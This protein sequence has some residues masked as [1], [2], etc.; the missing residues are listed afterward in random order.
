MN[1]ILDGISVVDLSWGTAG[2]IATMLLADSGAQVT[3]VRPPAGD[4]FVTP[5][6]LVWDRQKRHV[7]FDLTSSDG[8]AQLDGLL[9]GADVLIDS[10]PPGT[11]DR[12]GLDTQVLATHPRLVHCSIT[13]YGSTGSWRDRPG[14]DALVQARTG[15]MFEQPGHREAPIFHWVP[16]PSYGAGILA[17]IGILAALRERELSGLGQRVETS[18]LQGVLAWTTM[19]WTRVE[20]PTPGYYASYACKDVGQT[21]CYEAGDGRWI[22][23]MP[24]V[25]PV[26]LEVLGL[27]PDALVGSPS[28]PTCD[29]RKAFQASMQSLLLRRT[30]TEWLEIFRQ[31]DLRCQPVQSI[32]EAY[33]HPQLAATGAVQTIDV[34]GVGPVRQFGSPF[35]ITT[36][37][38]HP[39][40]APQPRR[41]LSSPLE[42][43]TVLDFGLAVAGPYGPM[44]LSDLGADVIRID[45]VNAPRA[46]DNQVWA[47]CQRGKRS[48]TLDLKSAEGRAIVEALIAKA[49][50][51][52]HNMRP[53]VAERL[54]IGFEQVRASNPRIVYCHVTG[55]G[56]SGPL[57]A[58]P[59][60]DQM[61][62]AL[63]G[64]D[65]EQGATDAGGHPTWNRL[66]VC[67]HGAAMLSVLGILAALQRRERTGEGALVETSITNAAA[68]FTSHVALA[69]GLARF[70][71]LDREQTG[72]G[73][74]YR[75][76]ETASGWICIAAVLP[77]HW[78]HLC[79]ALGLAELVDD[80]RFTDGPARHRNAEELARM[81]GA[82]LR[83]K[84]A[85]EWVAILDAAD[86]PAEIASD[87]FIESWFDDP[88]IVAKG[89]VTK[90]IHPVWGC[91]EQVG[92]LWDFSASPSRL[93]GPPVLHGQHSREILTELGRSPQEIEQLAEARVTTLP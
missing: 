7:D 71:G 57:A 75:L 11:L 2:P 22:H 64:L 52:H 31:R 83:M 59:G 68:L 24:E 89:W 60:S 88:D 37:S 80:E 34:E 3:R 39:A 4:P 32:P 79:Q 30:S 62:Q 53:G 29:E 86:V 21:A 40:A 54:G 12:L 74:L 81:V 69:D 48:I 35:R 91:T 20:H 28:A 82:V 36:T 45:N 65:H 13:A 63:S 51:I 15:V 1:G 9:A 19:P 76:Y 58:A 66:G 67:D 38:G 43:V 77:R 87:A 70:P 56:A 25:A 5:A 44:L 73:S 47:A 85:S 14:Y 61:S 49:D 41:R 50:V 18:L 46:T 17:A 27:G 78:P 84:P 10:F 33:D 90:Y 26:V 23:P 92:R 93:F 6:S 55:F 72:L 42:G 8:R 16:L